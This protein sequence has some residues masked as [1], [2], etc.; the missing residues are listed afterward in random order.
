M[1]A[2]STTELAPP[3]HPGTATATAAPA[4]HRPRRLL[5]LL[6]WLALPVLIAVAA[7]VL[8]PPSW[9]RSQYQ[10][11]GVALGVAALLGWLLTRRSPLAHHTAG[12]LVAA[13]LPA[14]TIIAL[15]GTEWFFS[16]PF[17]DQ[18]FRLQY[19]AR[20][21]D[22]LSL[23][24]YTYQDVPAFYSPGWFWVVGLVAKVT[25]LSSWHAYKWVAIA[26]LYLAVVL[27]FALWRLTCGP[28]LAA[29]LVAV[30]TFGLPYA[31]SGWLGGETLFFAGAYEPYGWLV[32]LPLPALVTWF[33]AADGPFSWR[34]G[35]GLGL[36]LG[37]AA[38]LYV[39]YAAVAVVAILA[40]VVWR[41]RQD[42]GRL[43][44]VLV[45]GVT[46]AVLVSPW[47]G[48]FLVEWLAAG[49]PPALA[50]SW[51][52]PDSYVRPLTVSASPWFA[53]ALVGAVGLLVVRGQPRLRGAQALGGAAMLLGLFQIV[54]G[55][56][57]SGALF[58]RV[59]LVLGVAL[60]AGGTLL[61][62]AVAPRLEKLLP[63]L[64]ALP[65]PATL[66]RAAAAGLGVLFLISLG[67]HTYEWLLR[68]VDPRRLAHET[69]YPDGTFPV[70]AGDEA[71]EAVEGAP[72]AEELAA[73]IRETAEAAGQEADG[74]VLTDDILLQATTPLHSY[75]QWWELYANPLGEYAE[76]RAFLE[77]LEDLPADEL[78]ARLR[79]NPEGPTVFALEP[80]PDDG[81]RLV[82][83][84]V[85]W[86][87]TSG[88][89]SR[90]EVHLPREV[91]EGE[92]F[93]STELG[94]VVVAALRPE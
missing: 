23:S 49:R 65:G 67:G 11:S 66:R 90:W 56:L 84:S 20:F 60:L 34:R 51:V 4:G 78:V 76:R 5:V 86:A 41:R 39:L 13:T 92:E 72:S 37:L 80:D 46:S 52:A 61:L 83:S 79:Q 94:P 36:A 15:H 71:R 9:L 32:A 48:V 16:G 35:L 17:G 33:A 26:S 55:Q 28:R 68:D 25:G 91:L 47:L 27:A 82:F 43:L 29:L 18:S 85:A 64:P 3:A 69:P 38:W 21:A 44:E 2:R 14:L 59:L 7:L 19:A 87:P 8:P 31:Q 81:S 93:A 45:A 40:A 70:L 57:G 30:T 58:H 77:G 54:G 42:R 53:L 10:G 24:D 89:S 6:P 62:V 50:T 88:T 75:Q 74:A 22:D 73:A 63:A 12:A 1:T